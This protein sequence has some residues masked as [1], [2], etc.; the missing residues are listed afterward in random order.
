MAR[1]RDRSDG[2]TALNLCSNRMKTI[3]WMSQSS[4]C[5]EG[6]VLVLVFVRD[7][8]MQCI[9]KSNIIGQL[10][11]TYVESASR[12]SIHTSGCLS[13]RCSP[14]FV[15]RLGMGWGWIYSCAA[16]SITATIMI[17]DCANLFLYI[18]FSF[19][20]FRRPTDVFCVL[21][22]TFKYVNG[23]TQMT[24]SIPNQAFIFRN[25]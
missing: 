2:Q 5:F 20:P 16:T 17:W 10:N 25:A 1:E 6:R 21:R 3:N 9:D 11:D 14:F 8:L 7:N 18:I 13:V 24:N 23:K 15:Q 22:R 4:Q 12:P 19:F